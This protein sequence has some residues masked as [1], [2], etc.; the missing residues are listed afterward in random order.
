MVLVQGADHLLVP[1]RAC[2]NPYSR[3]LEICC[4]LLSNVVASLIFLTGILTLLISYAESYGKRRDG[5]EEYGELKLGYES[6][7]P[8]V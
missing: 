2:L 4:N 8:P 7:S 1:G 5:I 6:I 3:R